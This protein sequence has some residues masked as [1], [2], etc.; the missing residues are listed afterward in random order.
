MLAWAVFLFDVLPLKLILSVMRLMYTQY[1]R[2]AF[3]LPFLLACVIECCAAACRGVRCVALRAA[4]AALLLSCVCLAVAGGAEKNALKERWTAYLKEYVQHTPGRKFYLNEINKI[5]RSNADSL[6]PA[7]L[8]A[9][10]YPMCKMFTEKGDFLS[11]V[12]FARMVFNEVKK[13]AA[14]KTDFLIMAKYA[15][16]A[17]I[18]YAMLGFHE[19]GRKMFD[20][21]SAIARKYGLNDVLVQIYTNQAQLYY[22]THDYAKALRMLISLK[23]LAG[24]SSILYNNMALVYCG[25][26]DMPKAIACLDSALQCAA[27]N[28]DVLSRVY[29]NKGGLLTEMGKYKEAERA[30]VMAEKTLPGEKFTV[31]EL[32]IRLNFVQL[33]IAMGQKHKALSEIGYIE[34]KV[35]PKQSDAIKGKYLKEIATLYMKLNYYERA[36]RCLQ[37][38][39]KLND[40]LNFDNQK[41]QLFQM[42][43]WYD[44]AQLRN[45]NM[46]L[47]MKYD[48]ANIKLRNRTIIAVATILVAVLLSVLVVVSIKKRK[49]E[50][51]QSAIILEQEKKLRMLEQKEHE[52]EKKRMESEIGKKSRELTTFSIDLSSI[53]NLHKNICEELAELSK[54]IAEEDTRKRVNAISLKLRQQ[55]AN[56]LNEGFKTY[57]NEVSPLFDAKLKEAHPNLTQNDCRLC[58][59]I[60]MGLTSKEISQI[61]FREVE[62]VE[63]SRNRLRKKISLGS[64]VSIRGYL[65]SIIDDG[66]DCAS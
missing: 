10:Y 35:I 53:D 12:L 3:C 46:E 32:M 34:E 6:K 16:S 23:S 36:S 9:S 29:I 58:A 39:M 30:L 7:Q 31:S 40:S 48:F 42:M 52:W 14:T 25:Q 59:Y 4:V 64:D 60:Y 63:K 43:T 20:R 66:Q 15:N 41:R 57:F 47:K 18:G 8:A 38:S 50:Q 45:D 28:R 51:R 1:G 37:E 62:S 33:Y 2:P 24:A 11:E 65:Q 55:T 44:I 21:G 5:N 22:D 61:T 49:N 54:D 56:R 13:T 19:E 26:K 27:G 17:G